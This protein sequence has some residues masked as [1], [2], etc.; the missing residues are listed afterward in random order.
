MSLIDGG[1]DWEK[2]TVGE[3]D[4]QP[5]PIELSRAPTLNLGPQTS[6]QR[7]VFADPVAFR[8]VHDRQV[9]IIPHTF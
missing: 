5:S 8:Y 4:T 9:V 2:N 1:K 7:L 6:H 3:D